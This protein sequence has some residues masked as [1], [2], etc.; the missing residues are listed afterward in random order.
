MTFYHHWA[1]KKNK[2]TQAHIDAA[3]QISEY[4]LL[5]LRVQCYLTEL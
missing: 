1:L 3:P 5:T 2:C 4:K